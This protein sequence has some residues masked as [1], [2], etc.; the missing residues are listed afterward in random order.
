VPRFHAPDIRDGDARVVLPPDEAHHLRDVLRLRS[1]DAVHVFDGVGREWAGSVVAAARREV[2][3][4]VAR[5]V[6]PVP[7]PPV[8]VTLYAG[9]LRGDQ[10][11]AVVR[12]ATMLGVHAIVP[13]ISGHVAVPKR[14]TG[15]GAAVTRWQ[16]VALASVKQCGRAVLPAISDPATFDAAVRNDQA[17]PMLICL[18]P[19][20]GGEEPWP[21]QPRP[22]AVRLLIGPEGGWSVEEVAAARRHGAQALSLGPRT[23]RAETAPVVALTKLWT[24]WGW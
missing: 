24:R 21:E 14:A 10:M 5:A 18:E 19:A 13:L 9:L 2:A 8:R 15:S 17:G 23:L 7:E 22:P 11:D 16:R 12:D 6:T 20:R 1:G 4:D 3:I